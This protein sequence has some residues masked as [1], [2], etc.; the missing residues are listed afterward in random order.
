MFQPHL[1]SIT[2]Q[3]LHMMFMYQLFHMIVMFLAISFDTVYRENCT[4][5]K[6]TQILNN[7]PPSKKKK[8]PTY[9]TPYWQTQVL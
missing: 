5:H 3:L 9:S 6:L 7:L 4:L 8:Q 2:F 1:L